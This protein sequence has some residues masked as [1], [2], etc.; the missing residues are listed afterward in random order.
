MSSTNKTANFKLSQFIGTDK[1]TFLGD[2]N[3]DMQIIDGAL[4]TAGQTAE[5]AVNDVEKV[6]GAQEELKA[7]HEDTK[8]QVAQLKET[9]D[10]MT[11]DVT[12][13]QEAA[14]SAEEKATAAQTAATDVVNAANT[15]SAN[16]TRAKQTADGNK[17]TL[18]ELDERVTALENRP[19]R[20]DVT[21]EFH[22][23]TFPKTGSGI[24]TSC[25]PTEIKKPAGYTFKTLRVTATKTQNNVYGDDTS[26]GKTPVNTD[27]VSQFNK[28]TIFP[29]T[30][31]PQYPADVSVDVTVV[32][33]PEV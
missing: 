23:N 5:D 22:L 17:T 20:E 15:A 26:L 19:T 9:A 13:A 7:V 3:N 10:G 30:Y 4:F 33:T 31:N 1:P 11:G 2:Y 21:M 18:Q 32:L 14:N 6:K 29:D 24:T 28:I 16:A 8:Q 12:A 25:P 27:A